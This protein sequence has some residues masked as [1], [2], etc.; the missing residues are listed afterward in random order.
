MDLHAHVRFAALERI[1]PGHATVQRHC[2]EYRKA[3]EREFQQE[4]RVLH[5]GNRLHAHDHDARKNSR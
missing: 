5:V 1:V 4:R 2:V 3:G